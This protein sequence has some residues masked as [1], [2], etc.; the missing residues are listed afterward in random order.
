[1]L[2][3]GPWWGGKKGN[4]R[5]FAKLAP[6][7]RGKLGGWMVADLPF[8]VTGSRSI[9]AFN[10]PMPL[11]IRHKLPMSPTESAMGPRMAPV[12]PVVFPMA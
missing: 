2:G 7:G 10:I 1:M 9:C 11:V 6:G 8:V 5:G 12:H 3:T 4:L